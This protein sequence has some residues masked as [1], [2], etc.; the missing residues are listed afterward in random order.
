MTSFSAV[1][2]S[3]VTLF[4]WTKIAPAPRA[5]T[6]TSAGAREDTAA[7]SA[8]GTADSRSPIAN[9]PASRRRVARAATTTAPT[10]LPMPM[11]VFSQPRL[12]L[13]PCRSRMAST[14]SSTS[15]APSMTACAE[16]S[17]TRTRRAGFRSTVENPAV[18]SALKSGRSAR[19]GGLSRGTRRTNATDQSVSAPVSAKTA[20]GPLSARRTP[21]R[22]GPAN[23]P[24]L[25]IVLPTTFAAVSS[26]G[27]STRDGSNAAW[28]GP[29]ATAT[30]VDTT[31]RT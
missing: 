31:A 1:R 23:I 29:Y 9:P 19:S 12:A 7:Q 21:P 2:C 25:E 13:P 18:S 10:M 15:S 8:S 11:A 14:T 20:A 6:R 5:P 26:S 27:V 16:L 30:T 3:R 24:T 28:A 4:T 22:A 17:P